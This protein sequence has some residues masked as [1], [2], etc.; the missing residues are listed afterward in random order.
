[1]LS[2]NFSPFPELKT[3]RLQLKQ[4]TI[5]HANDLFEMRSDKEVMKYI[6][7]PLAK[8]TEDVMALIKII[9][10]VL[11]KNDG[12]TWGILTKDQPS[13]LIGTV[14]FWQMQKEHYRAEIGYMLHPAW[15]GK[16]IMR[17]A[18]DEV[19]RY[20]F[21]DM[22][23]HSVEANVNPGNIASKKLLEKLGFVQEA[24]FKENYYA[25]G[26][27]V[28]SAIYSLLTPQTEPVK[29]K[30]IGPTNANIQMA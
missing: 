14:G 29:G 12:I 27:F 28:D 22:Q 19:L 20:G 23:L 24:Y 30:I 4:I 16:G 5:E 18:I 2:L 21:S 26:R 25:N 13:K 9:S 6:D 17:E 8:S 7:R 10:E 15:Q 1:M 11:Q 3:E